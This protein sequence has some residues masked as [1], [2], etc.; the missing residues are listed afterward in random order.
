[1]QTLPWWDV[2]AILPSKIFPQNLFWFGL[3]YFG[4]F[5]DFPG[6][7]ANPNIAGVVKPIF[8]MLGFIVLLM[9]FFYAWFKS[10]K[11][12]PIVQEIFLDFKDKGMDVHYQPPVNLGK[13]RKQKGCIVFTLPSTLSD[14]AMF[15]TEIE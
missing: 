7:Y 15:S 1:M 4:D 13:N 8:T 11:V 3:K 10:R 12:G 6:S 2:L 5:E 9:W 14:P